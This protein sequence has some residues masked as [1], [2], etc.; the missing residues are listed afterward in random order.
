V[1]LNAVK[2][3]DDVVGYGYYGYYGTYGPQKQ[4]SRRP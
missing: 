1:V 2:E 3:S 4:R